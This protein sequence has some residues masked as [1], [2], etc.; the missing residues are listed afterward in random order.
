[1]M[2][3]EDDEL[4]NRL[5]VFADNLAMLQPAE[6]QCGWPASRLSARPSRARDRAPLRSFDR[7]TCRVGLGEYRAGRRDRNY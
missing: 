2:A 3:V 7:H 1:M 5:R 6:N 4:Q